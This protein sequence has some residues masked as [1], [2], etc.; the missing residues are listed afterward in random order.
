ML[1]AILVGLFI[2]AAIF[3]AQAGLRWLRELSTIEATP[4]MA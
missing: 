3:L 2:E 4:A 1:E